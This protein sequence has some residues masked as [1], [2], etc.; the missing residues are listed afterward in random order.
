MASI[1]QDRNSQQ[2]EFDR[3]RQEYNYER[4]H[5]SLNQR[6]P[7]G[8]YVPSGREYPRHLAQPEYPDLWQKRRVRSNGQIRWKG[9][10][11]YVSEA[12]IGR[13]VG[14]QAVGEGVW[15]VHFMSQRLGRIEERRGRV[16]EI[17]KPAQKGQAELPV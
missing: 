16:V 1:Q 10:L 11:I 4:P 3:V 6:T 15:E 17:R 12:L 5:E 9:D 8:L 13:W 7:G 14:L 2:R